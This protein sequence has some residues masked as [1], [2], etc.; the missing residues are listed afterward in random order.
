MEG[1]N[2]GA[3]KVPEASEAPEFLGVTQARRLSG[4]HS[5][6]RVEAYTGNV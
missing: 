3:H 5:Y 6:L 4:G 1:F 2:D